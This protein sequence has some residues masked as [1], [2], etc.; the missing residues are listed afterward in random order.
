[1]TT[2]TRVIVSIL[3]N[4]SVIIYLI[5]LVAP[6]SLIFEDI[7]AKEVTIIIIIINRNPYLND[8]NF[9]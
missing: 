5:A 1:M 4:V 8:L 2:V 6:L 7:G 3:T 9:I